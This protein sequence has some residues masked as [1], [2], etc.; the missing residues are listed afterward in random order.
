MMSKWHEEATDPTIRLVEDAELPED[1]CTI[2]VDALTC[3]HVLVI[4]G[5]YGTNRKCEWVASTWEAPP[6]TGMRSGDNDLQD[7]ARFGNIAMGYVDVEVGDALQQLLVIR[8]HSCSANMVVTKWLIVEAWCRAK[9][10]HEPSNVVVVF[11]EYVFLN[12]FES[13][14]LRPVCVRSAIVADHET[15]REDKG[16]QPS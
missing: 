1:G 10:R 15:I 4:E 11:R 3:K 2:V 9:G 16:D 8:R 5:E 6:P 7:D 13:S 14:P 12:Q